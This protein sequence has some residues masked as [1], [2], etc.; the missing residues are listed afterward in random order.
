MRPE[1]IV[2]GRARAGP[3]KPHHATKRGQAHS[4]GARC[5]TNRL[6]FFGSCQGSASIPVQT[7]WPVRGH[8]IL[9]RGMTLSL[10]TLIE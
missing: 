9:S 4:G 5:R 3:T 7:S 10:R 8:R 6:G 2:S 1:A